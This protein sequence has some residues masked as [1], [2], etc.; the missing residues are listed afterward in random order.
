MKC[1]LQDGTGLYEYIDSSNVKKVYY[2]VCFLD[3]LQRVL[4]FTPDPMLC[5]YLQSARDIE[6]PTGDFTIMLHGIGVSLVD[7]EKC[8]ELM[9]LRI[10]R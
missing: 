7:N 9:Y 10:A 5:A 1:F 8:K 4:L 2:W 6:V 3:G